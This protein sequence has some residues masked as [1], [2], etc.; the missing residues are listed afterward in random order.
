[1]TKCYVLVKD[2]KELQTLIDNGVLRDAYGYMG[3]EKWNKLPTIFHLCISH[4]SGMQDHIPH[5][6]W[7]TSTKAVI[8][9]MSVKK[10]LISEH[11]IKLQKQI[12]DHP[13]D[14]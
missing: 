5:K 11:C 14:Y 6:D 7:K 4:L 8:D 13:E 9:C 3:T 2:E 10:Y 12:E 1:M